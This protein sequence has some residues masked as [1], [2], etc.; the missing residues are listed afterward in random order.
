PRHVQRT[1]P[2]EP[3]KG[4]RRFAEAK[5]HAV[6]ADFFQN[7]VLVPGYRLLKLTQGLLLGRSEYPNEYPFFALID[8]LDR[9]RA[10]HPRVLIQSRPRELEERSPQWRVFSTHQCVGLHEYA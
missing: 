2:H 4:R 1:P 7:F 3:S 8:S 6:E 5:S 9:H 10:V